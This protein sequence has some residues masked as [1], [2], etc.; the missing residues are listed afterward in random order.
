[1]DPRVI[2]RHHV[3]HTTGDPDSIEDGHMACLY[4]LR[5]Q[6]INLVYSIRKSSSPEPGPAV[7]R[8]RKNQQM[9]TNEKVVSQ[10]PIIIDINQKRI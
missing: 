10:S 8:E 6:I 9:N 5:N 1:M 3:R 4:G 7:K 2:S